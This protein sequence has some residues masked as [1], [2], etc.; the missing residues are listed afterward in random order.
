MSL[1]ITRADIGQ[2]IAR[3]VGLPRQQA[4]HI[5][6][7]ILEE[8]SNGLIC[9]GRAKLSSFG[10]FIVRQKHDRV[11]RNPKTGEEIM[12]TPRRTLLFR[13]SHLLKCRVLETNL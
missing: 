12:I 9:D 13:A 10:S 1:T 8:L 2:A 4:T 3:R 5:M 11:G 7:G 6:D